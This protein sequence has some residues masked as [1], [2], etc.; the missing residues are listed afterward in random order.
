MTRDKRR[1][2]TFSIDLFASNARRRLGSITDRPNI[3][4]PLKETR[5][6]SV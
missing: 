5:F 1:R 3:L 4:K 6:E 2:R